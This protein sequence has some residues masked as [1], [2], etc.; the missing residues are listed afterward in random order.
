MK[1]KS[2]SSGLVIAMVL[3]VS[4]GPQ[5]ILHA[6]F[7]G[8]THIVGNEPDKTLPE[9]LPDGDKIEYDPTLARYIK[10][11]NSVSGSKEMQVSHHGETATSRNW[12]GFKGINSEMTGFMYYSWQ[13]T[14]DGLSGSDDFVEVDFGS[15]PY[16]IGRLQITGK[17]EIYSI[18]SYAGASRR[19]LGNIDL[20][21]QNSFFVAADMWNQTFSILFGDAVQVNSIPFLD[22]GASG[23]FCG[24]MTPSI[25]FNANGPEESL[26]YKLDNVKISRKE[27]SAS[28]RSAVYLSINMGEDDSRYNARNY[29]LL[30][31]RGRSAPIQKEFDGNIDKKTEYRKEII[32]DEVFQLSDIES[33]A[34][35]HDGSRTDWPQHYDN[36]NATKVEIFY[37]SPCRL[38][39]QL[40]SQEGLIHWKDN[41]ETPGRQHKW[42]V[43]TR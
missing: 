22:T 4:C 25:S 18:R 34:I 8:S 30:Y 43:L 24:S 23:L 29:L 10:I 6:T 42:S 5:K 33:V 17:G 31:L 39:T 28:G 20:S 19:F 2:A 16:N 35:L 40:V 37:D 27:P 21:K 14:I 26:K 41:P 12:I 3:L 32:F 13:M 7:E 38:R 11:V 36:M 1:I 9:E 15:A